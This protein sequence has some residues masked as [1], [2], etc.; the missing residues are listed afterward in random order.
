M[1]HS[2]RLAVIL[3]H[4]KMYGGVKRFF[5]IGNLLIDRGHQFDVFTP[6][7][8]TPAWFNFRGNI[9]PLG[10]ID[11]LKFDALF[12]TEPEFLPVLHKADARLKIF[13]AILERRN[14]KSVLKEDGITI[15]AN[16]SKMFAY[17]GGN[18]KNVIKTIGGI[19]LNRFPY[20]PRNRDPETPFTVMVYGR[21]YRKK[22]GTH[23]VIRACESLYK[24]GFNIRLLLFDSPVEQSARKKIEDFTVACP[25]EFVV[26]YPVERLAEVYHRAD[27]FVSAE[28]NAGWSNTS[29]EAMASGVPL[30][31][32]QSGTQD[33]LINGETGLAIWRHPFF[34]RRAIKKLYRNPS[35][36]ESLRINARKKIEEF[37][38]IELSRTIEKTI[39]NQLNSTVR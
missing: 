9:L 32:T 38:W 30:I 17:L 11:T 2:L 33:F 29:A 4:T 28:R 25:F 39:M 37:S 12:I 36:C 10:I 5:E 19:D 24:R 35:L 18:S 14:I 20:K 16:S 34:I 8:L 26:D 6:D 27:V 21:F 13:Y 22:K 23:L 15:F 7:A 3:P 1:A 31:A